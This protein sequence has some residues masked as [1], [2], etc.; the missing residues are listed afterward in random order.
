MKEDQFLEYLSSYRDL[1]PKGSKRFLFWIALAIHVGALAA[2]IVVPLV[3]VDRDLPQFESMATFLV[4]PRQ[5]PPPPPGSALARERAQVG[6]PSGVGR[7]RG[8]APV[9]MEP[10]RAPR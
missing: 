2:L 8:G 6:S 10:V 5:A 4:G 3:R 9:A 1:R 7:H